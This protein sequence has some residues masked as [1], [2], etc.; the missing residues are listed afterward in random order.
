[1][2]KKTLSLII[3]LIT[4]FIVSA[5]SFAFATPRTDLSNTGVDSPSVA[6]ASNPLVKCDSV[7]SCTWKEFLNTLNRVKDYGFQLVVVMSVIFIVYAGS[8]YLFSAGNPGKIE[9]AKTI[10]SNVVIGF[11]LAAAGWLIVSA[12]LNTLGVTNQNLAP[13]ELIRN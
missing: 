7:D 13:S 2:N 6:D 11:F 10:I 5:P 8:L 1:M 3:I 12:I 4:V 9:Q